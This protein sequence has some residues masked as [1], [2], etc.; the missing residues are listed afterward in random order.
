MWEGGLAGGADGL[1]FPSHFLPLPFLLHS[2]SSNRQPLQRTPSAGMQKGGSSRSAQP[3]PE[4]GRAA[5]TSGEVTLD[6]SNLIRPGANAQGE[7]GWGEKSR[8]ESQAAAPW[9]AMLCRPTLA[10]LLHIQPGWQY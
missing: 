9:P 2:P 4:Q 3:P 5:W 8:Q 10:S 1:P 7:K 6:V